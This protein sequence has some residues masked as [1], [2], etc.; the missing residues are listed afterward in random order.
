MLTCDSG[1]DLGLEAK[2]SYIR[3]I[4][5]TI[6]KTGVW[7]IDK[8]IVSINFFKFNNCTVAL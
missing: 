1:L 3:D 5:G 7:I 6:D 2:K 4:I 8:S